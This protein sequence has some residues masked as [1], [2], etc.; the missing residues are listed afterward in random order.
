MRALLMAIALVAAG[1]NP[2][3]A[4]KERDA[5]IRAALPPAGREATSAERSRL[6]RII[7]QSIDMR[8]MAESAL[9]ERWKKMTESQRKRLIAAFEKRFRSAGSD[10]LDSY[11]DTQIEYRAEE[12]V[13]GAIQVPTRVTIKGEPTE[14]V[15]TMRRNSDDWRI[16]DIT[17]DGVSTVENYRSSFARVISKEG[18]EGLIHRLEKGPTRKS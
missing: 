9:G 4:L 13:E 12:P 6:E 5:E 3:E 10:Q 18:I 8:S 7:T 14:I 11:R 2:T 1:N 16:V 17:V 15:Y